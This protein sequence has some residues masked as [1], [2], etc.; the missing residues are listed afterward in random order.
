MM[1]RDLATVRGVGVKVYEAVANALK[2]CGGTHMF[3]LMGDGNLRF[4]NYWLHDLDG[5]YQG[6]RH[7]AAGIAA[8]DGFTRSSGRFAV[9]TTTQ[10]PGVTNA[11]TALVAARK[12]QSPLVFVMGDV[13]T[14]QA[15][16]PQ[17]IDH[18][19]VF[20]AAGVPWFAIDN[21]E[22]AFSTTVNA[23]RHAIINR[24]PVGINLAT[25]MG[26]REW[27]A[28]SDDASTDLPSL[29]T[30]FTGD[31]EQAIDF[32]ARASKP[33]I[34]AGRGVVEAGCEADLIRIGEHVGA[35]Y[36]T[37][38][39]GKGLFQ[40]EEFCLGIAGGLGT[41]LAATM[42]GQAD[43]VLVVG[44]GL[45]DF[46]TVRQTLLKSSANVVRCDIDESVH[47]QNVAQEV[48]LV[49][50]AAGSITALLEGLAAHNVRSVGF[51]TDT[52][53]AELR[54]FHPEHEIAFIHEDGYVDPR[55]A[56]ILLNELLP[57]QRNVV[58]DAGRFFGDPC[59]FMTV[60]DA[61]GFVDGISFGSIGLGLGLA[62][63]VSAAQ[64]DR[65]TVLFV[66]DGGLFMSLG[67]LETLVRYDVP[68]LVVVMNDDAYGSELQISRVWGIPDALSVFRHG[69]FATI[70][71]GIGMR[72]ARAQTLDEIRAAMIDL[73]L[74]PG[75]FLLDVRINP[76]VTARW[77]DDA[78]ERG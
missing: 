42:L 40:G 45:N 28:W 47:T 35:I 72:A 15:G 56:V 61:R 51:R 5:R 54:D 13:A 2:E 71:E 10:G 11:L 49:G 75:P 50:N 64:P 77:L 57:E 38:L 16:W 21:A 17:D 27:D 23:V 34:I 73:D 33:A 18:A 26:E 31:I 67:E 46:T 53:A 78:F 25:D 4:I 68:M 30:D 6:A 41:N 1:L 69:D 39:K 12:S 66:G 60:P 9:A 14:H 52:V 29:G 58:T 36:A 19:L 65:P 32:F 44:A 3:G 63:G 55:E 8:A 22:T 20:A 74:K 59:S 37:T 43:T 24:I 48:V 62:T 7:E 70:A 76:N